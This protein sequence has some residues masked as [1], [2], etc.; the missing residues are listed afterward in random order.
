MENY[1]ADNGHNYD[2]TTGGGGAKIAKSMAN[3]SGWNSS[4]NT[5]AVGNTDYSTY[6]NKSGFTALPGGYRYDN[7]SCYGIGSNG[8]WWSATENGASSAW[9]RYMGSNS[10]DVYR[11]YDS[12]EV[13]FSV[14]CLRD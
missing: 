7:G 3:T 9:Y 11:D 10:S 2:G 13:G 1:L 8:Y 12:K 6:R 14:R 4:S 5:G